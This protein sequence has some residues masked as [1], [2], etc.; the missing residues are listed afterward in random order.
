M[1]PLKLSLKLIL[2]TGILCINT[3]PKFS[4]EKK[5]ECGIPPIFLFYIIDDPNHFHFVIKL[6]NENNKHWNCLVILGVSGHRCGIILLTPIFIGKTMNK[7]AKQIV[8]LKVIC[9]VDV[10]Q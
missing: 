5:M 7:Y 4:F 1:P 10:A 3:F 8:T 9:I 6:W 2:K